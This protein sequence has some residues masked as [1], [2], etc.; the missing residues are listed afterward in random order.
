MNTGK[1]IE[2]GGINFLLVLFLVFEMYFYGE[3]R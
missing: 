2:T 1:R 3:E